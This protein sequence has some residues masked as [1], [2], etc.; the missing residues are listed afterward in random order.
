MLDTKGGFPT[1]TSSV[2]CNN[3]CGQLWLIL[4]DCLPS[5]NI[6]DEF[7]GTL[8]CY[9]KMD[10]ECKFLVILSQ[11]MKITVSLIAKNVKDLRPVSFWTM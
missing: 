1:Y 2:F 3:N 10:V 4:V 8:M 6:L 5:F 7:W 9:V 11:Y